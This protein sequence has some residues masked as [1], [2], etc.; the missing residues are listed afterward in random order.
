MIQGFNTEITLKDSTYHIQTELV[1]SRIVSLIFLN[2]AVI[3][4]K[5]T[6]IEEPYH[7]ESLSKEELKVLR[8][9]MREQHMNMIEQLKGGEELPRDAKR[10]ID[11]DKDLISKFL[12][13][14]AQE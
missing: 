9:S 11:E 10:P 5:Q 3:A 12:D 6:K 8:K 14:W 7:T 1:G 13:E 2:G 4:D